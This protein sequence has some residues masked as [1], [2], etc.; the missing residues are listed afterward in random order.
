MYVDIFRWCFITIK[1][2]VINLTIKHLHHQYNNKTKK[3]SN[4]SLSSINVSIHF[5]YYMTVTFESGLQIIEHT[6]IL[7]HVRKG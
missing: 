1:W 7:Y 2:H 5:F 3:M 4:F 6:P